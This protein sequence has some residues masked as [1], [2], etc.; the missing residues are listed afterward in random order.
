MTGKPKRKATAKQRAA[1]DKGRASLAA[2]HAAARAAKAGVNSTKDAPAPELGDR[3]PGAPDVKVA[4]WT[5][6]KPKRKA[7]QTSNDD[8]QGASN[9]TNADPVADQSGDQSAGTG[10]TN[11]DPVADP[12]VSNDRTRGGF[13]AELKR[14]AG[15]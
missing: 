15:L 1:L 7:P 9:A 3:E 8:G 6:T 5:E 11:A 4:G 10:V 2:K 13:L 12:S 14:R